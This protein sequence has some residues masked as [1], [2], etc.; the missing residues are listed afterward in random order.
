LTRE[1]LIKNDDVVDILII[2]MRI[3]SKSR[4][5]D[6]RRGDGNTDERMEGGY[7]KNKLELYSLAGATSSSLASDGLSAESCISEVHNVKLSR[8]SC[9]IKVESL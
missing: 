5:C 6:G 1:L 4:G 9:I 7:D 8:S 2:P 3:K